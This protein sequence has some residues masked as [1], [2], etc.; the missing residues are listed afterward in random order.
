MAD[1]YVSA[2]AGGGGAGTEGDPFTIVE[3]FAKSDYANE[4]IIWIKDGAYTITATLNTSDDHIAFIG[5]KTSTGDLYETWG[6]HADKPTITSNSVSGYLVASGGKEIL[7]ANLVLDGNS[8]ATDVLVGGGREGAYN[9]VAKGG[10]SDGFFNLK[11]VVACIADSNTAT[12]FNTIETC[13]ACIAKGN[14]YG[15][16]GKGSSF[17]S[18][19]Y[20]NGDDGWVSCEMAVNCVATGNT[21][22]GFGLN[23]S[24]W[25]AFGINCIA[26]DNGA[27]GYLGSTDRPTM[28][29]NCNS[30]N[31]TSGRSSEIT[32]DSNP[33]T[34]DPALTDPS[35]DDY[36]LGNTN[37]DGKGA[38]IGNLDESGT[39]DTGAI[40]KDKGAGSGGV[41]GGSF[42]FLG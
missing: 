11:N 27:Y 31:N 5:Y 12:G 41:S 26:E 9:C 6:D 36:S 14:S 35:S 1:Y 33:N 19:A 13:Y 34:S 38:Y 30:W 39:L 3:A 32:V 17:M 24:N 4:D 23:S 29:I 16:S 22:D 37:L 28:L 25:A 7:F 18:V 15:Y 40:Q 10:T 2:S 20:N 8:E 42:C 21:G